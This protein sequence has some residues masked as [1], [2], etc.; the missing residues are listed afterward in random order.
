LSEVIRRHERMSRTATKA[1]VLE[2]LERVRIAEPGNVARRYAHELSGGMAQ[3]VCLA[4]ALAGRP[5]V[6][7]AD[8]PTTALDVTVQSEILELLRTLRAETGL[9]VILV[10]HDW[11]VVADICDRAIVMYAGQVVE[12]ASVLELFR[13][14]KHPYSAGLQGCDPATAKPGEALRSIPGTVAP[15]ELWTSCCRFA[16]RCDHRD[17]P[18]L[19]GRVEMSA[20]ST[21][22]HVRCRRWRELSLRHEEICK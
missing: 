19:A 12:Q 1:R 6:V 11:G 21:E 13:S 9:A 17:T 4:L 5:K 8:E 20:L 14:P 3:R 15:P 7:I 10:T 18:C 16:D 2:L 22:H